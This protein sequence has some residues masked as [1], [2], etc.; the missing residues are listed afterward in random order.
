VEDPRSKDVPADV[1]TASYAFATRAIFAAFGDPKAELL[2]KVLTELR[3]TPLDRAN[4][5]TVHAAYHAQSGKDLH[6]FLGAE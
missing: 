4:I 5:E 1:N 3:K 6:R 2:P